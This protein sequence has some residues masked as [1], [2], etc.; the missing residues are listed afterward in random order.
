MEL[1]ISPRKW[2]KKDSGRKKLRT[3]GYHHRRNRSYRKR[4]EREAQKIM[5]EII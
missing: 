2:N 1:K 5:K 4:K 3:C